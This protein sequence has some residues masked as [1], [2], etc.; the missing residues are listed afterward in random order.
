LGRADRC[1]SVCVCSCTQIVNVPLMCHSH[2][3]SLVGCVRVTDPVADFWQ[4]KEEE[5][6]L[7]EFGAEEGG[8]VS[9]SHM[10]SLL[11]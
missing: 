10:S 11:T 8:D 1:V 3:G 7:E 4:N 9:R 2:V 5:V 6:L